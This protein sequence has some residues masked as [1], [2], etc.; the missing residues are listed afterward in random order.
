M[1]TTK[2]NRKVSYPKIYLVRD[3]ISRFDG[4]ENMPAHDFEPEEFLKDENIQQHFF[5]KKNLSL[6]EILLRVWI[7][8]YE[9]RDL[10]KK[11]IIPEEN[12][13]FKRIV[14]VIEL[15]PK[16]S[17]DI[18]EFCTMVYFEDNSIASHWNFKD[19]IKKERLDKIIVHG[20]FQEYKVFPLFL[21]NLKKEEIENIQYFPNANDKMALDLKTKVQKDILYGYG[22]TRTK[23]KKLL[24]LIN[25]HLNLPDNFDLLLKNVSLNNI[26]Y[27]QLQHLNL[28]EFN[29]LL[30]EHSFNGEKTKTTLENVAKFNAMEKALTETLHN[31]TAYD[32]EGKSYFQQFEA[33]VEHFNK[34]P[35][36]KTKIVNLMH[37]KAAKAVNIKNKTTWQYNATLLAIGD[38]GIQETKQKKVNKV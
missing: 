5:T 10:I 20:L 17:D 37:A 33:L 7:C 22:A 15:N 23:H 9:E 6:D 3:I 21:S 12:L 36:L 35:F 16:L 25:V 14:K 8:R 26:H 28:P 11:N 13:F 24:E 32:L 38:K 1:T 2:K 31:K 30:V 18:Y 34:D 4:K 19:K 27:Y 29:N